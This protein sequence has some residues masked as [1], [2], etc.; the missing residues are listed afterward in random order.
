MLQRARFRITPLSQGVEFAATDNRAGNRPAFHAAISAQVMKTGGGFVN[1]I[2][3]GT[4]WNNGATTK[5][6]LL[7]QAAAVFRTIARH[8]SVEGYR[9]CQP[10]REQD[11]QHAP[12][13]IVQPFS[14]GVDKLRI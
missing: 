4:S 5:P 12:L 6:R 10:I 8:E 7:Y 9:F 13:Q 14:A 1:I 2:R 3:L 11:G